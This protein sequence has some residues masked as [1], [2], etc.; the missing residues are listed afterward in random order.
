[1]GQRRTLNQ[2]R[3]TKKEVRHL[4]DTEGQL[5]QEFTSVF[6]ETYVTGHVKQDSVYEL[7]NERFLLVFDPNDTS[8]GGKGDIYPSDYFLRFIRWNRRVKDDYANNRGSS[9]DHWRF[10]SR[11]KSKILEHIDD[12]IMELSERLKLP[13]AV[14]DRS[15]KS[16]DL[17]SKACETYGL[18]NS[19]ETLYDNLVIY[20]G[21][22]I[23][24]RVNGRWEINKI[25]YG[26]E[27]PYVAVEFPEVQYMAVNAVWSALSG[28]EDINLR[29]E[30]GDEVK[31]RGPEIQFQKWR[32]HK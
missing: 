10:Y 13:I 11:H 16:L 2:K 21:E 27:Y 4:I 8:L 30:A 15:Y 22:V 25:N 26:G 24:Q 31:R 14:L 28:L 1:M 7:P 29:K 9:V 32:H 12:L 20:S 6:K 18:E 17:V 3:L 23:K 19:I 5:H